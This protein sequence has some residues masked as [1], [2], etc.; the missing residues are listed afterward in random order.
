[1]NRAIRDCRLDRAI[2]GLEFPGHLTDWEGAWLVF[3]YSEFAAVSG[4]ICSGGR[5]VLAESRTTPHMRAVIFACQQWAGLEVA[6]LTL[7]DRLIVAV[8]RAGA[9]PI[10]IVTSGASLPRLQ[11]TAALGIAFKV[12][13][14]VPKSPGPALIASADV[15]VHAAEL[16]RCLV[17]NAALLAPNGRPL[18]VGVSSSFQR[19]MDGALDQAPRVRAE[20]VACMVTD[21]ASARAAEAALWR[22][23]TS[24]SDGFVDKIF[25]RPCGR[26][27]SKLLVQT[28][29][30]PNAVSVASILVGVGAAC[31]FGQGQYILAVLGAILF[32]LSAI[33]DCVDGDLARVLF[34]ESWLGKWLDLAG[35]QVVHAAVFTGV[36]VGVYRSGAG[37][38]VL[39]LGASAVVGALI[40]F[41]VVVRGMRTRASGGAR[42]QRLIGAATNRDFSV[43][44]LIL[45][46]AQQ[47]KLFLWM[48][49]IGS[50]AFWVLALSLQRTARPEDRR[51]A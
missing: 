28:P 45:A 25:N 44:V 23:M 51:S 1:V 34:K 4:A 47:L 6:G 38:E 43:L 7:L 12:E 14:Q 26:P 36:A 29:I 41:A 49:A 9:G 2:R 15:L 20:T 50:H 16:R 22:S 31:C 48:A 24:S 33:L 40:S 32:Q 35:D 8:Y 10:T 30:S 18:P 19:G 13:T 27:L 3:N 42:L 21:L 46:V 17:A 37:A 5:R 39:W 11:R